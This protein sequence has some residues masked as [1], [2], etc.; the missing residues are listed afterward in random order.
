MYFRRQGLCIVWRWGNSFPIKCL[1][2]WKV[3]VTQS[4]LTLCDPMDCTVHGILLAKILEWVVFP[5]SRGSSQPRDRTQVSRISSWATREA[6]RHRKYQLALLWLQCHIVRPEERGTSTSLLAWAVQPGAHCST[7][8]TALGKKEVE[9]PTD[10]WKPLPE[11]WVWRWW[12]L[13]KAVLGFKAIEIT[14][15]VQELCTKFEEE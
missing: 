2:Y 3:K 13:W 12:H 9:M 6:Q 15:G 14:R 11:W 4:C 5:F 10:A 8:L 7:T 1:R